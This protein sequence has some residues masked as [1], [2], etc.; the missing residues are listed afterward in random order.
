MKRVL[1]VLVLLPPIVWVVLAGP[2]W[3]FLGLLAREW[4]GRVS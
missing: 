2:R 1:T 3:A 4:R